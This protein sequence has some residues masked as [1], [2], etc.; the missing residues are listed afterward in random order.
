[1]RYA[2]DAVRGRPGPYPEIGLLGDGGVRQVH[3][4]D[5][6]EPTQ[7]IT[8]GPSGAKSRID[9]PDQCLKSLSRSRIWSEANQGMIL[10]SLGC[11]SQ[12]GFAGGL[13][14]HDPV[15][16]SLKRLGFESEGG[17]NGLPPIGN[18]GLNTLDAF[19]S[20]MPSFWTRRHWSASDYEEIIVRQS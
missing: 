9:S 8:S 10:R 4:P 18:S 3:C 19:K 13:P 7:V 11:S 17:K 14:P 2:R 5:L 16:R 12:E 20:R 15:A 1:M 6:G